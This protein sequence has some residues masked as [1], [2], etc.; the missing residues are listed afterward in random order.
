MRRVIGVL[1]HRLLC[2]SSSHLLSRPPG[3]LVPQRLVSVA[4]IRRFS[5]TTRDDS[6]RSEGNEGPRATASP[7]EF[8]EEEEQKTTQT[9][10]KGK[11]E[12]DPATQIRRGW[13][14]RARVARL[15]G[16]QKNSVIHTVY[17]I[18]ISHRKLNRMCVLL[19]RK[20]LE[21]AEAQLAVSPLKAAKI[22]R[23]VFFA[24]L[25]QVDEKGWD[26][27][28]LFVGKSSAFSISTLSYPQSPSL[29]LQNAFP[30]SPMSHH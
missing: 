29:A 10:R 26:R 15:P 16:H 24:A 3:F 13:G 30:P 28:R 27:R 4:G 11:K 22:I 9:R 6:S 14:D 18:R 2:G 25:H 20:S 7:F 12:F 21:Q 23:Q 17:H 5:S 8:G 1:S 19:R